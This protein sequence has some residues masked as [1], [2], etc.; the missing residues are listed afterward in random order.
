MLSLILEFMK[1]GLFAVGGGLATFP[2][3][4]DISKNYD[5]FT[6]EELLDM[7]AVSE[8][9]PGPVGINTATYAGFNAY[10]II[11]SLLAT[12]SLV[13]PAFIIII[14]ISKALDKFKE[15]D[16]IKHIF[17]AVRPSTPGL[18]LGAMSSIIVLSLFNPEIYQKTHNL[19]DFFDFLS[20]LIFAG[21]FL[22]VYKFKNIHP[23]LVILIGA[24]IGI[25]LNL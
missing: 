5:W 4:M 16:T 18:I 2:F 19:I 6:K 7:I 17:Y 9:T 15:S 21:I 1:A 13:L 23:I 3:L 11:G 25:I 22:V 12:F 10:G 20:I 24:F 14:F 8:S